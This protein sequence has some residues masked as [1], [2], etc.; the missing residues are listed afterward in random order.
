MA[1]YD[2]KNVMILDMLKLSKEKDFIDMFEN[3]FGNKTFIGYAFDSSDFEH[4]SIGIQNTFKRVTL[5]DLRDLYQYKYFEKAK[6][7][8]YMCKDVLGIN[9]CK[10]EQ[11]SFWENRPLKQSQL[12]YA[13][14]DALVCVSLYKK[15]INS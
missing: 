8:K 1:N 9:L 4:F 13:A 10:Y 14:I 15:L 6:G 2:E 3:Y 11:C 5:I 12:H 7:L